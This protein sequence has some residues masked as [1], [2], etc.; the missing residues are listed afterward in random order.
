MGG[1]TKGP[2][3]YTQ[4]GR[5]RG[6]AI[7]KRREPAPGKQDVTAAERRNE[8]NMEGRE[9]AGTSDPDYRST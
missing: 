7:K 5:Q 1:G 2:G 3:K 8:R 9:K 6:N 4:Y